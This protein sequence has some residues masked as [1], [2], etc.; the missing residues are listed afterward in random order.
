[1]ELGM[2]PAIQHPRRSQ[3]RPLKVESLVSRPFAGRGVR[4]LYG[5]KRGVRNTLRRRPWPE[6]STCREPR[7][8]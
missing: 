4:L 2:H 6:G 5:S 8:R 7:K 1:M 3:C